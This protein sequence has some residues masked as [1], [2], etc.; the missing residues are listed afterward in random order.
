[1]SH[2]EGDEC[3]RGEQSAQTVD[4]D[5]LSDPCVDPERTTVD[6]RREPTD[7][8]AFLE[9]LPLPGDP[10]GDLGSGTVVP[11]SGSLDPSWYSIAL[12]FNLPS[13]NRPGGYSQTSPGDAD[14]WLNE[15]ESPS[16][17]DV[18]E[19]MGKYYQTLSYGNLAFGI[20]TPRDDAGDPLVPT[21]GSDV[22]RR[23]AT[24]PTDPAVHRHWLAVRVLHPE[25]RVQREVAQ[26]EGNLQKGLME[27]VPDCRARRLFHPT[28]TFGFVSEPRQPL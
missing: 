27:V 16:S 19:F 4:V 22:E 17:V 24:M 26:V 5:R 20:E 21:L 9:S 13:G 25:G 3:S 23:R 7:R 15:K 11:L 8:L 6:P 12:F 28:M 2:K 1:M 10:P 14:A 18:S